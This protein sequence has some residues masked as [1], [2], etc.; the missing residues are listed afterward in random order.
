MP[1]NIENLKRM[2]C[3]SCFAKDIDPIFLQRDRRDGEAYCLKCDYVASPEEAA[4][5]L[6]E[7][8]RMKYGVAYRYEAK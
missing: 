3:P 1:K 6:R 4:R 7:L 5:F 2:I 8:Q